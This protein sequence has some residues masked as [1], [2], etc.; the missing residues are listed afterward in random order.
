MAIAKSAAE[1]QKTFKEVEQ[2]MISLLQ[3]IDESVQLLQ[4]A[5]TTS[6]ANVTASLPD[7]VSPARLLQAAMFLLVADSAH[8]ND[9]LQRHQVGPTFSLKLYTI[10]YGTARQ[11][12]TTTAG[13][14][15]WKEEH[16][17]CFVEIFR[18]PVSTNDTPRKGSH[19]S[20]TDNRTKYMT[21]KLIYKY[22]IVITEDL[23]DDRY[24]EEL[25]SPME[26][27]RDPRGGIRGKSR[28]IDLS[29]VTRL[30]FSA[31][32]RLLDIEEALSPV[33]VVK[34]NKAFLHRSPYFMFEDDES[35]DDGSDTSYEESADADEEF[36]RVDLPS[37]TE[38]LAFELYADEDSS[39]EQSSGDEDNEDEDL[40][41]DEDDEDKKAAL[42]SSKTQSRFNNMLGDNSLAAAFSRL[43]LSNSDIESMM[44]RK[45]K[46]ASDQPNTPISTH[47]KGITSAPFEAS[48]NS[49]ALLEYIIR[50]A[51]LQTND[52]TSVFSISDER[53][54]LYLRD[55]SRSTSTTSRDNGGGVTRDM[56]DPIG[57]APSPSLTSRFSDTR[58]SGGGG[59]S[60]GR[61]RR[62]RSSTPVLAA[63]ALSGGNSGGR[64]RS[65]RLTSPLANAPS[66]AS[67]AQISQNA[68]SPTRG[69]AFASHRR[70]EYNKDG[71]QYSGIA[72][73][74][75]R[76]E[77]LR[78]GGGS[79]TVTPSGITRLRSQHQ[80][81]QPVG[82]SPLKQER[83]DSAAQL[84][85]WELDR[86]RSI[87]ARSTLKE[88]SPLHGKTVRARRRSGRVGQ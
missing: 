21:E 27:K 60:G 50:L 66:T 45:L 3:R 43:S 29:I 4:L 64:R 23:D 35:S 78:T 22:E 68:F 24:H 39:T 56:T 58:T 62:S 65:N 49:L 41:E 51:A 79:G 83:V 40:W 61:A 7:M 47:T 44:S 36:R 81:Q 12:H 74:F 31:S 37:N 57:P 53:I 86:L 15:T 34:L 71:G 18:V 77:K 84:T 73:N 63:G 70:R 10:F 17:K 8:A 2:Y 38:W 14:I 87:D 52:Q 54:S 25:E 16:A 48:T 6:G 30:F 75:N 46:A 33:L 42:K 32:G 88:D 13:D 19:G 59:S 80:Q 1:R 5:I 28:S 85:P 72:A 55:D 76:S 26:Y 11:P 82:T 67:A 69:S 9:P 20:Q